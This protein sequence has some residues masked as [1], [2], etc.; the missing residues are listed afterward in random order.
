MRVE[1]D[2]G[3]AGEATRRGLSVG[4]GEQ[5]ETRLHRRSEAGGGESQIVGSGLRFI[6]L[7]AAQSIQ[8]SGKTRSPPVDNYRDGRELNCSVGSAVP[9]ALPG[10]RNLLGGLV[11]L[12]YFRRLP[13]E[14]V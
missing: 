10:A 4:P 6:D 8:E 11:G 14:R 7:S 1:A 13:T 3:V 5:K 9:K 2:S 12:G